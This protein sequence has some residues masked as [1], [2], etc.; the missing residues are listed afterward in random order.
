MIFK[1]S[2]A[3]LYRIL[4]Y[5]Y[6]K[7]GKFYMTKVLV[8]LELQKQKQLREFEVGGTSRCFKL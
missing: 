2:K 6:I 3:M 1:A 8:E 7:K 4:V 5:E